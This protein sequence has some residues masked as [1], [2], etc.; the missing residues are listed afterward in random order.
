MG[1]IVLHASAG[2]N[3]CCL[4]LFCPALREMDVLNVEDLG[5]TMLIAA[6]TVASEAPCPKCGLPS[7]R[8]HS[9]YRRTV[10]DLATGGRA[11]KV[12]LEVRRFCGEPSCD[13]EI[14]AEQVGGLTRRHARRSTALRTL[15]T[16]I[17]IALAG[18]AGARMAYLVGVPASPSTLLRTLRALPDPEIGKVT[19]LGVDDFW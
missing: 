6:R 19:V 3:A 9:R 8:V 15:L 14:F 16:S 7:T 12:E 1:I 5:D 13:R 4:R 17:A 10:W 11:V 2:E 18:R